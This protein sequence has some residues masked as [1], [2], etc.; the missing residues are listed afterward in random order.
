MCIKRIIFQ[1]EMT[2]KFLQIP[3]S[4]MNGIFFARIY[5]SFWED[6]WEFLKLI[7]QMLNTWI[8]H[9]NDTLGKDWSLAWKDWRADFVSPNWASRIAISSDFF[10]LKSANAVKPLFNC[11]CNRFACSWRV[12]ISLAWDAFNASNFPL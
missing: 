10:D 5:F 11:T 3:L 4:D 8:L 12:S 9:I 7:I 2:W 1:H 6:K